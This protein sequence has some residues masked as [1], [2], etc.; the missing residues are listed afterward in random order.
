[1]LE[2]LKRQVYE[3]NMLL[4]TYNL[5]TF[6]WGNASGLD[7]D[8]G[9]VAIKPSGVAYETL[10]PDDIVLLSLKTGQVVEG[11]LNPSSDA[12]THLILYRAFP[13]IGGVVHTHS[14]HATAFAQAEQALKC[15]GTT[16]ADT[17]YGAVP[18]TRPLTE[19][20]IKRDYEANTGRVIVETFEKHNIDPLAVPAALVS[21]HAPF[22]WG[23]NARAAADTSAVL[24]EVAR[25]AILTR[26]LDSDVRAADRAILDKHY[27]RKHGKDAYYGQKEG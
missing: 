17:F 15:Y 7:V 24:E 18:V 10:S 14:R 1:M 4:V 22:T 16:H 20:E 19:D 2:G 21:K 23:K 11:R 9:I 6:T 26:T 8:S 5:V 3:A 27:L 12:Q 25:M 13:G